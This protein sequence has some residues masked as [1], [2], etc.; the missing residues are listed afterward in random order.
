MRLLGI[1][2]G[3]TFTDFVLMDPQGEILLHKVPSTPDNPARAVLLGLAEL[4]GAG[5]D[6]LR[7][8]HGSTVATNAVL[9]RRG[10]RTALITT[11]GFEDVL[12]IGRQD[13]PGLYALTCRRPPPLVPRELRFGLGERILYNGAVEKE[14][15]PIEIEEILRLV[16]KA[17]AEALAV[18]LLHS[19][20]APDHE[21]LVLEKARTLGLPV[22]A[23]HQVLR[24]FREY[25]RT[26]TTVVNAY[27]APIMNRYLQNLEEALPGSDLRIMQSN[28]GSISVA[29]ARINPVRTL[30][31]G[32]AGGVCGAAAAAAV[33][34]LSRIISFDMGGT[35]T[36]VS[37]YD[38][39]LQLT[40]EAVVAGCP[41]KTPMIRIHTVGAGGGSIARVDAGGALVVGPE[42]AGAIPGPAC[43]GAG[44]D[45]TVTDANLYLGRLEPASF[46]GG[47]MAIHP[48]RVAAPLEQLARE[49]GLSP[50]AFAEGVIRVIN[51]N[52]EKA[53]RVISV[54]RGYDP[55][56]FSLVT[57]GGAGGLHACDLARALKLK[58]VLVPRHPGVLS[59]L[60]MIQADVVVDSSL[61]VLCPTHLTTAPALEEM[62]APLADQARQVLANEGFAPP[63]TRIDKFVDLRYIGQSHEITTPFSENFAE[64]F[65]GLHHGLF[66]A[67]HP[68]RPTEIVTLRLRAVG[69]R[70]T[71]KPTPSAAPP[72]AGA[73]THGS[74]PIL[75]NGRRQQA[76][77]LNRN[78]LQPGF[79]LPGPALIL[80]L[81]ATTF[82]PPD[83]SLEVDQWLNLRLALTGDAA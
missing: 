21:R 58:E 44:Q 73:P 26:S 45:L 22:S 20:A 61:T 11:A 52:M 19:Y 71:P 51:A 40:T 63:R 10:A 54:E 7:I 81:S 14:P 9:E 5:V 24:E 28:G 33:A 43:Y 15:D 65:H 38:G 59:A 46:L 49:A 67:S 2:T 8:V 18:C 17:G 76:H 79:R 1:D 56:D 35:S 70:S 23:S 53:I 31:S 50:E 48:D 34:G 72:D 82:L 55:R 37:L 13:R 64:L 69:L 78:Q 74:R 16:E 4:T 41:V 60:G 68:S 29:T 42:S 6:G 32:P 39:D 12:E 83:F 47:R 66:G 57:F 62:F 36:D 25:E 3:G 30:L 77:L 80:E 27:V 75:I